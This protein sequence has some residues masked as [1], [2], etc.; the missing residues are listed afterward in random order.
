[1][2]DLDLGY[3]LTPKLRLSIGGNNIFD[4]F[5]DENIVRN[6]FNGIFVYNGVSPFGFNGA[7]YYTKISVKVR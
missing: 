2:A 3:D 5:P 1:M 4:E 7:Y 6:S